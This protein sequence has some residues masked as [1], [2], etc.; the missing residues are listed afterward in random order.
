MSLERA[1]NTAIRLYPAEKE[2][3]IRYAEANG[4]NM[5]AA[6]RHILR[7]WDALNKAGIYVS[8][9]PHPRDASAVPVI[10]IGAEYISK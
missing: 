2:I 1:K 10:H 4:L 8:E 6:I 9:L 3:A 5:S 7:Q